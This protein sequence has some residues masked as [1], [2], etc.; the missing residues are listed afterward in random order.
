MKIYLTVLLLS[1][2]LSTLSAHFQGTPQTN[3]KQAKLEGLTVTMALKRRTPGPQ[4]IDWPAE[5]V[6]LTAQLVS[7]GGKTIHDLLRENHISP[8]VEAFGI[9]YVLNPEIKTLKTLNVAQ[10]RIPVVQGGSALAAIFGSGF[11]VTVTID[12]ELKERF[13]T[14][15]NELTKATQTVSGFGA[16]KF[17]EPATKEVTLNS[18]RHIS[19]ALGRIN[20]RLIQRF[21]RPIP[22]EALRQLNADAEVLNRMLNSKAAPGALIS[23]EER[24]RIVLIEKDVDVK[25]KAYFE[26]AS[27]GVPERWPEVTVTVKTLEGRIEV[28]SLRVYYVPQALKGQDSEILSFGVLSSPTD[29]SI[30]EADYCFWAAKDPDKSAVTNE[31]CVEIRTNKKKEVQLTVLPRRGPRR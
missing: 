4:Q 13:S 14:D 22:T 30:P 17:Q 26:T 19:G 16:D 9:V 5:P 29:Q 1:L 8:D 11:T 31:L 6:T 10:L 21:G 23:N 25:T 12:K 15:V 28:P 20:D 24:N 27:L 2:P 3:I 18:L 7:V